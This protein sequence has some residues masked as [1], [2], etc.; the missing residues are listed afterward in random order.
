MALEL[1]LEVNWEV[2]LPVLDSPQKPPEIW[3]AA[4]CALCRAQQGGSSFLGGLCELTG[5]HEGSLQSTQY[6]TAPLPIVHSRL[7]GAWCAAE[8]L[9]GGGR[10]PI[11]VAQDHFHIVLWATQQQ[12]PLSN[13]HLYNFHSHCNNDRLFHGCLMGLF[14]SKQHK[15]RI[16]R[17]SDAIFGAG[18]VIT[19]QIL[20]IVLYG[21][22]KTHM[23]SVRYLLRPGVVL[24]FRSSF[25]DILVDFSSHQSSWQTRCISREAEWMNMQH[26]SR[27]SLSRLTPASA[28]AQSLHAPQVL[29]H[30]LPLGVC[31]KSWAWTKIF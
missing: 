3:C 20:D 22:I 17:Y 4:M 7:D 5:S 2:L 14:M 30:S 25:C 13:L 23:R 16:N 19:E 9:G 10:S 11:P 12:W 24:I 21:A 28:E 26:W 31:S 6:R 18:T 1:W 29:C 27:S 8:R 15:V